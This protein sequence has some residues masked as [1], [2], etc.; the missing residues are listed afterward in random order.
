MRGSAPTGECDIHK[1]DQ[2]VACGPGSKGHRVTEGDLTGHNRRSWKLQGRSDPK[3]GV[4]C[5]ELNFKLQEAQTK[6]FLFLNVFS[7]SPE[8]RVAK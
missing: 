5:E 3:K 6:T 2:E 4:V 8:L 7:D 1:D